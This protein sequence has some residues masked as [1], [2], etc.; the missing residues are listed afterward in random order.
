[1]GESSLSPGVL[2]H[3]ALFFRGWNL[4]SF[5]SFKGEERWAVARSCRSEI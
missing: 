1:M 2:E 3:L 4:D 5:S